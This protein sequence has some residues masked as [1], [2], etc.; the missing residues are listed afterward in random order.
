MFDDAFAWREAAKWVDNTANYWSNFCALD[1]QEQ[2]MIVAHWMARMH[3]DA[4][5]AQDMERKRE[6]A[7]R[8]G[9]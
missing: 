2:T 8:K 7:A 6:R 4:V 5:L 9:K 3:I 1:T